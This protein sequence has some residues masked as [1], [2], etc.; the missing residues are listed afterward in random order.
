MVMPQEAGLVRMHDKQL[1]IRRRFD[2]LADAH[3][4]AAFI[5]RKPQTELR[6]V[7]YHVEHAAAC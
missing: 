2:H 7:R 4:V 3:D 6:G 5:R 1:L